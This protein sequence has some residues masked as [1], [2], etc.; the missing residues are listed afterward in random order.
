MMMR[1]GPGELTIAAA[2]QTPSPCNSDPVATKRCAQ[3]MRNICSSRAVPL[4]FYERSRVQR[5][6][7]FILAA[8]VL[9]SFFTPKEIHAKATCVCL[10]FC[11]NRRWR[12]IPPIFS[13][14]FCSGRIL[15][16]SKAVRSILCYSFVWAGSYMSQVLG[17]DIQLYWI[18]LIFSYKDLLM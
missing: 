12:L 8:H 6:G 9:G 2:P 17:T 1:C 4:F 13:S 15:L 16:K 5:V 7:L 10:G 14:H 3:K 18:S 11:W